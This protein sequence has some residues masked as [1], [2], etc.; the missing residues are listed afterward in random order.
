MHQRIGR[1][2]HPENAEAGALIEVHGV[3]RVEQRVGAVVHFLRVL[4]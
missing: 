3:E 2:S 1:C 4:D